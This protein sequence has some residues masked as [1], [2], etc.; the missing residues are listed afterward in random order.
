[1]PLAHVILT[2][3]SLPA[4]L[5]FCLSQLRLFV[6]NLLRSVLKKISTGDSDYSSTSRT[7]NMNLEDPTRPEE[8]YVE[9]LVGQLNSD[10]PS[11]AGAALSVLEETTQDERCLRSLVG[12]ACCLY[13]QI[14]FLWWV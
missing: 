9:G 3:R 1:M 6:V 4:L 5:V 14:V 12:N 10:D 11:V 8:W 13:R 2:C 7:G